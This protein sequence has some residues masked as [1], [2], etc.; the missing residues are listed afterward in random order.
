MLFKLSNLDSNLALTLGYLNPASNNL[1]LHPKILS[2][3]FKGFEKET[4]QHVLLVLP[5]IANRT[6]Y[7]YKIVYQNYLII[8][9]LP[10]CLPELNIFESFVDL[11]PW[12]K[13]HVPCLWSVDSVYTDQLNR[14]R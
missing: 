6:E 3:P 12:C 1:A 9:F 10:C 8:S 2:M 11:I 4:S 7:V 13:L 5:C 14:E